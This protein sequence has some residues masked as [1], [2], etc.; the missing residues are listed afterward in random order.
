MHCDLL[1]KLKGTKIENAMSPAAG[2]FLLH[3]CDGPSEVKV[4][5]LEMPCVRQCGPHVVCSENG[6]RKG[7][8]YCGARKKVGRVN[9][10]KKRKL[11]GN[12]HL[13]NEFILPSQG[14]EELT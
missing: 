4:S 2:T 11:P 12:A 9:G 5:C 10:E 13:H 14:L 1:I 6:L 8:L 3:Y 7:P